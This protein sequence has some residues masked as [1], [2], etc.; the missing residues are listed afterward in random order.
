MQ[1]PSYFVQSLSGRD[2]ALGDRAAAQM[3]NLAYLVG[4]REAGECLVV[5]PSWDPMGLVQRAKQDGMR[6]VGSIVTHYHGDHAGGNLWGHPVPGVAELVRA[7]LGP[8]HVQRGDAELLVERCELDASKV[9]AHDEGSVI[10]VGSLEIGVWHTPGHSPGSACFVAEQA[11]LTGDTLFVQGCG[12]VD[13]DTSHPQAM[14]ASLRRLAAVT[15]PYE[16]FPG[17]DYGG[18]RASLQQVQRSNPVFSMW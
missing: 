4:D 15:E 7:G 2:H 9:V 12:R 16:I 1:L 14:A 5:D 10:T 3:V 18:Q 6:V 13:L 8:V 11:L 17:H